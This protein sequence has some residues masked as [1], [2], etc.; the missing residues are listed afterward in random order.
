MT[1]NLNSETPLITSRRAQGIAVIVLSFF[2]IVLTLALSARF[3]H[4]QALIADAQGDE[5]TLAKSA[6]E[7]ATALELS[8]YV[9]ST[10]TRWQLRWDDQI[11]WLLR[12]PIETIRVGAMQN[13][14][15]RATIAHDEHDWTLAVP[16]LLDT[17]RSDAD[18]NIRMMA[19]I[20]LHAIGDAKSLDTIRELYS[21]DTFRAS[22][23]KK[24]RRQTHHV[25]VDYLGLSNRPE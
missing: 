4:A 18:D 6:V 15:F 11:D 2:M 21:D 5:Y 3:V 10:P 7:P 8:M 17:Y 22:L 25:L 16:V 12:S 24:L 19:L 1:H 23:P 14:I 20:G 13:V 9:N